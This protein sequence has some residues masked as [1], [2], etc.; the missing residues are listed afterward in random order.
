MNSVTRMPAALAAPVILA[1]LTLAACAGIPEMP[2]PQ[3]LV[4]ADQKLARVVPARGVQIYQCRAA[5]SGAGHEWAFVAP[6]AQ[7]MDASGKVIG[8]H[9]A[10]PYWQALDG[11]RVSAK[12]KARADAPDKRDT[13]WLL[14]EARSTGSAGEF[15]AVTSIQRVNT[16]GGIAP[17]TACNAATAGREAR[18]HYSA[19]YR[20]FTQR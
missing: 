10:G 5:K 13:P 20:F 16:A 8:H 2:V 4:P 15:S 9:G 14:L 17:S 3:A 18:V 12:L 1:V 6:D 11:S 19:D 7:L